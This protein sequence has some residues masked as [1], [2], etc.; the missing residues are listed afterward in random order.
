[1]EILAVPDAKPGLLASGLRA[2]FEEFRLSPEIKA[3]NM[4]SNSE[5]VK[6]FPKSSKQ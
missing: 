4:H 2:C 1:M 3:E 6:D 5:V